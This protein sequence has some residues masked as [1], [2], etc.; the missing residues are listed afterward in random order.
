MRVEDFDFAL[1]PELIAQQPAAV[2]TA[3]RLLHVPDGDAPFGD[4]RFPDLG[5]LLR[6]GDLLVLNDTR[7]LPGRL[8]GRK[9][10]GGQ[11]EMLL[12]REIS[13]HRALVQLRAS[14]PPGA[15]T[16]LV[17]EGKVRARVAG[18]AGQFFLLDFDQPLRQVLHAHGHVPLPPY[19]R[20]PDEIRDRE[21]YQTVYAAREG[22][23]AAPTAGLHFDEAFLAGL[24]DHG[25]GIATLTL[26]VGAGT[27]QP[28]REGQLASGRLHAER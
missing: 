11:I 28:L 8:H 19:I 27:F 9:S 7:V 23:V 1:P 12:E 14:H 21:R 22:A 18:R 4:L 13:S 25:V 17:F 3:S 10:S 5:N 2:R 15:G 6:P 24:R 26:H 16:E 20:R